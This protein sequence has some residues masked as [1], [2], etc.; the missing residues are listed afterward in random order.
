MRWI[1]SW[2]WVILVV[3]IQQWAA[4]SG[5]LPR[6]ER[7]PWL[8]G[9]MADGGDSPGLE[10]VGG[11]TLIYFWGSWCPI[12][13]Q[14]S[15]TIRHVAEDERLLSVALRSGDARKVLQSL[16]DEGL[17]GLPTRIDD[18]G[19]LAKAFGV[20]GVPALFFVDG[21]GRLRASTVGYT[22]EWGIRLR[23]WWIRTF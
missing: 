22:T 20:T 1:R 16:R 19:A 17:E 7:V 13:R 21:A 12:C 14:M 15:G 8:A 2:G 5:A 11:P 6:G 23:L 3:L 4:S 10:A 9:P 18:T